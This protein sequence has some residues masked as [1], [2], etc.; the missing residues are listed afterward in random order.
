[1]TIYVQ[2]IIGVWMD[3]FLNLCMIFIEANLPTLGNTS[4]SFQIMYTRVLH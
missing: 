1:M 3:K 2:Y 4:L